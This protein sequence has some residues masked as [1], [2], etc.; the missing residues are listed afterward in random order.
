MKKLLHLLTCLSLTGFSLSLTISCSNKP[1][2][3]IVKTNIET[4]FTDNYIELPYWMDINGENILSIIRKTYPEL[5]KCKLRLVYST[6]VWELHVDKSD[7][8][9]EG[10]KYFNII[11]NE[12]IPILPTIKKELK[13][14]FVNTDIVLFDENEINETNIIKRIKEMYPELNFMNLYLEKINETHWEL[15]IEE[16]EIFYQ[17]SVVLNVTI[18]KEE[19]MP[20]FLVNVAS[21]IKDN[22]FIEVKTN[23]E[24]GILNSIYKQ[25]PELEN[26]L[27]V[28][29]IEDMGVVDQDKLETH[30]FEAILVVSDDD[31]QYFGGVSVK[32]YFDVNVKQD[33]NSLIVNPHIL[34]RENEE[35]IQ[36]N[37]LNKIILDYPELK[38]E[39]LVLKYLSNTQWE[40]SISE[41]NSDYQGSVVLNVTI[42]KEEQMPGFLV[43]VASIIKDNSFIE[44]KT[45]NEQGILNSI[46][47]Q[48]PELENRLLVTDIEDM[49]VVDQDKLE[50]H[51]FE[52][53]L[54]VSDDDQQYFGGVLVK[55]YFDVNV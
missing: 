15:S 32:Y 46:Y 11:I 34:L 54:V 1:I 23:N 49:G 42:Y 10:I 25:A 41:N 48:A 36:A 3:N 27:L 50:T 7:L 22:S 2:V 45:N 29:D 47:K 39:D 28:T 21:I 17:G 37:I 4:I 35:I 38:T 55:Y 26:R 18:Y 16:N 13:Q 14:V 33:L 24:Q 12:Q 31:Q 19:Q 30:L 52:A 5:K 8:Y 44:V 40:L 53:I 9:F 6:T 20:G 51:L 43:N